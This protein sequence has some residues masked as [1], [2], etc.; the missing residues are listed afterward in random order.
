MINSRILLLEVVRRLNLE[1]L[2]VQL[3]LGMYLKPILLI[4]FEFV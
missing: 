1:I 2:E 4:L 3:F